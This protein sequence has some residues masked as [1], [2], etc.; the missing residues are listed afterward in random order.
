MVGRGQA[1]MRATLLATLDSTVTQAISITSIHNNLRSIGTRCENE[2]Q[3]TNGQNR[4]DDRRATTRRA[5][6]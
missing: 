3:C 1:A 4:Q 5:S 6:E 2:M